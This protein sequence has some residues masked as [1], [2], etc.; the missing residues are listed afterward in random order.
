MYSQAPSVVGA[1]AFPINLLL[2]C[3][4]FD[5]DDVVMSPAAALLCLFAGPYDL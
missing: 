3:F 4:L 2:E 1:Y 5:I